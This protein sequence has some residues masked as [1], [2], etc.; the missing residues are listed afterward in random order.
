[1]VAAAVTLNPA[2]QTNFANTFAVSS[3]GYVQGDALDDSAIRTLLRKGILDPTATQVMFGGQA[4]NERKA[5]GTGGPLGSNPPPAAGL[6]SILT[7]AANINAGAAGSFT[8]FSVLN[9][10][11]AMI[12]TA[13]GRVPVALAGGAINFYRSGSGARIPVQAAQGAVA[14]WLASAQLVQSVYW[15]TV[16]LQV[17][18]AAGANIIGPLPGVT[19]DSLPVVPD[20]R[21]VDMTAFLASGFANWKE[22]GYAVVL[23]I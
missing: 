3:G 21:V 5:V 18:N 13:Q 8:G 22:G 7:P 11:T 4:I 16:N 23:K 10:A 2:L 6:G 14:A 1:M 17:T 9:Q 12:Q 15:D 19:L 20:S